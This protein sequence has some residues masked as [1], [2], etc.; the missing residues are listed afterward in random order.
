MLTGLGYEVLKAD[1]ALQALAVIRIGAHIDLLFTDVV[2]PGPLRSP[3]MAR[4][5]KQLLPNLKILFTS[6]YTAM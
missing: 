2:M 6:G 5:A 3:E 4:Q 1:D